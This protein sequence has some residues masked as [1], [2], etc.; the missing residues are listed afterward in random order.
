MRRYKYIYNEYMCIYYLSV[1]VNLFLYIL[2]TNVNRLIFINL[3]KQNED[4]EKFI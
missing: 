3:F 4:K 1:N 2:L